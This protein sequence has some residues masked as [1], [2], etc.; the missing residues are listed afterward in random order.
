MERLRRST[1]APAPS[2]PSCLERPLDPRAWLD[3]LPPWVTT[4]SLLESR[5]PRRPGAFLGALVYLFGRDSTILICSFAFAFLM[6]VFPF[7]VLLLTL[8]GYLPWPEFRET[9]FEGLQFFFP[10]SQDWIVRNLSIYLEEL[11]ALQVVSFILLAWAG[12]AFFF[13]LEAALESA[14]RVTN[15]R[16]FVGSQMLGTVLTFGFGALVFLGVGA[17]RVIVRAAEASDRITA[18]PDVIFVWVLAALA[19][20]LVLGLIMAAFHWLPN[21]QSPFL[22]I[23]PEA[24]FATV[25]IVVGNWLFRMRAPDLGLEEVYGPFYISVTILLWAYTLGCIVV[26]SARLG[27]NGFFDARY[28]VTAREKALAEAEARR[29]EKAARRRRRREGTV[30]TPA[31]ED[32]DANS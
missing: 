9:I 30:P 13:A 16:N 5:L 18:P 23:V 19:F 6:S 25:L 22:H 2:P 4:P 7:L 3:R 1:C 24:V 27:S 17:L 31:R 21:R 12:S 26:G 14:Y 28:R 20:I 8:V 15:P 10:V 11:G 32:A 29:D